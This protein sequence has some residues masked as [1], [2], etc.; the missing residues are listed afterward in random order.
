MGQV[1]RRAPDEQVL[2]SRIDADVIGDLVADA[3]V[4]GGWSLPLFAANGLQ[5]MLLRALQ[6]YV[7]PVF[8]VFHRTLRKRLFP[9][10]LRFWVD[11]DC[12]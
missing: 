4:Q 7:A 11:V 2:V 1:Q 12:L 9:S 10:C 8:A 6:N 3:A 5:R